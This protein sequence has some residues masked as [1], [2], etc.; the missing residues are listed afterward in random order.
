MKGFIYYLLLLS[1]VVPVT[2]ANDNTP[3]EWRLDTENFD[4]DTTKISNQKKSLIDWKSID[5][6]EWLDFDQWKSQRYLRDQDPKWKSRLRES[7]LKE[8]VGKVIK[9]HGEC[10]VHTGEGEH[11]A[12]YL[13]RLYEGYELE[14]TPNSHALVYL[15][16]GTLLRL[17]PQSQISFNEVILSPGKI[18]FYF[19]LSRGHMAWFGRPGQQEVPHTSEQETDQVFLPLMI[20]EAN[21]EYYSRLEYIQLNDKYK[22]KAEMTKNF[23]SKLQYRVLN[24]FIN[25]N[26]KEVTFRQ[27]HLKLSLPNTTLSIDNPHFE[28]FHELNGGTWYMAKDQQKDEYPQQTTASYRGYNN[29]ERMNINNDVW[30]AIDREGNT[31]AEDSGFIKKYKPFEILLRR[32]PSLL[33]VREIFLIQHADLIREKEW[34][35]EL[36]GSKYAYRLWD[37][38]EENEVQRRMAFLDE[39]TRRVETTNIRAV[40]MIYQNEKMS[41]GPHFYG[42]AMESYLR[43]LKEIY[44]NDDVMTRLLN[45]DELY[46]WFVKHAENREWKKKFNWYLQADRLDVKN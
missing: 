17:S 27:T 33:L 2:V 25:I 6:V 36:L 7:K 1:I 31:I 45:Q 24:N 32:I 12:R 22:M 16:D 9:C 23:G 15:I 26:N 10:I 30:Y 41:M 3:P 4:K 29:K 28:L 5:P 13:T 34:T 44:S 21:K 40:K 8:F 46:L 35:E 39:H 18:H 43:S 37:V 38:Q 42:K 20:P 19:R 11:H 14:L